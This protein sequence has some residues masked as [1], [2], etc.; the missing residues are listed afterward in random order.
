MLVAFLILVAFFLCRQSAGLVARAALPPKFTVT[1]IGQ[2]TSNF[3]N[4]S[5][6]G[7]GGGNINGKNILLFC[8]TITS[9]GFVSNSATYVRSTHCH[10]QGL[11]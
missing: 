8:D 7:G 9:T 5:R 2:E 1:P 10:S 4:V 11:S 6:D 3:G